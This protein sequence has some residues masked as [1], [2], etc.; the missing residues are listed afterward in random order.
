MLKN[1]KYNP[2]F[3]CNIGIHDPNTI[4]DD[5]VKGTII[6]NLSFANYVFV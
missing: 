1:A 2:D 3:P 5:N 4:N 6:S